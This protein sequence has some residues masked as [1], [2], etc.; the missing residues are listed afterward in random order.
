[1]EGSG[2]IG[3]AC[4]NTLQSGKEWHVS[5][6]RDEYRSVLQSSPYCKSLIQNS[7][8]ESHLSYCKVQNILNSFRKKW[9]L[10]FTHSRQLYRISELSNIKMSWRGRIIKFINFNTKHIYRLP[11]FIKEVFWTQLQ[12]YRITE[13]PF[14]S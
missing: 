3:S 6:T 8:G 13:S 9:P 11:V 14:K 4:I 5:L 1:M 12:I 2:L 7:N 10:H